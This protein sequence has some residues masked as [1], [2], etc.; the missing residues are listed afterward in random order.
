[1]AVNGI[2]GSN[3]LNY[4]NMMG[5]MRLSGVKATSRY[6]AVNPVKP[7]ERVSSRTSDYADTINFL[8]DYNKELT[9]LEKSASKLQSGGK[10]NVFSK[11]EV[12]TSD[13]SI[14]EA[15]AT[16]KLKADTEITLDVTS[17]AA[18]QKNVSG[19]HY[20]QEQV[21]AGADMDFLISSENSQTA[22]KVSS[23][24]ENGTQKTYNQMY[25]EAAKAINS[26]SKSGVTASVVNEKGKVSLVLT[27]KDTGTSH[28]FTV[29]GEAGAADGIT[30]AAQNAEDAVYT[31]T[32]DGISYTGKSESNRISLDYGRIEAEIKGNG[33][34]QLSVGVDKDK[35]VSAVE[36]LVKQYNS[37]TDILS[38]N[39][40]RGTGAADQYASF[41][42]G[43]ADEKTLE[44]LGITYNKDGKLELDQDVLKKALDE[45]YEGTKSFIG[46]QFGIA[47]RVAQKADSA[48]SAPVQR[49]VNKDIASAVSD[50][51]E[52]SL[53][54]EHFSNYVRSGPYNL[55]NFY[56]LGLMLNTLA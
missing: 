21:E 54:F 22:V 25:Q 28:E 24:N 9:E 12:N 13:A 20:S 15:K 14:V 53:S 10:D 23:V 44:Y 29:S 26:D 38:E 34:T 3:N 55:G 6:Q 8:T 51:P 30:M 42:R 43:M 39:A 7:V 50:R 19:S 40:E 5:I 37:V 45:D 31:V 11:Y 1:M 27:A 46:G 41:K 47:E 16:Y 2:S 18:E 52:Q 33:R 17:V 32:Q 36:D 35:V 4:Q 49:I 56:A 48:L